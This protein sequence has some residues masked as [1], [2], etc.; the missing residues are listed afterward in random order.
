MRTSEPL[1]NTT[2]MASSRAYHR[3]PCGFQPKHCA[4]TL[5]PA[6]SIFFNLRRKLTL[7]KIMKV[8]KKYNSQLAQFGSYFYKNNIF[9]MDEDFPSEQ[10]WDSQQ[11][12]AQ[13]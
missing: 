1:L 5:D 3:P 8:I 6:Y 12:L 13:R 10:Q 9:H 7:L 11:T 4:L 2:K